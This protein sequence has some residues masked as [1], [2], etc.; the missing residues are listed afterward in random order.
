MAHDMTDI[1]DRRLLASRPSAADASAYACDE[2]LLDRLR[3][4]PIAARRA[5]P[6]KVATPVAAGVAAVAAGLLLLG[7]GPGSPDAA[8][9]VTQTLHWLTPSP[10]TI[11]H[12]RSVE[13]NRGDVTTRD[14]WQS[15]DDPS[16]LR[17]RIDGQRSFE[18]SGDEYYDPATN[19]IYA[20]GD[21]VNKAKLPGAIVPPAK[22]GSLPAGDPMVIK[23]RMLLAAGHMEVGDLDHHNG[24][25]AWPIS[26][27]PGLDRQPWTL[28]VSADDG[29]PLELHDGYQTIRWTAYDVTSGDGNAAV[30]SVRAAHPDAQVVTD[31][32]AVMQAEARLEGMKQEAT[33]EKR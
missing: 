22:D 28:W 7:G 11:L 5:V 6:V 21:G 1:L 20:P 16:K 33:G 3:E 4:Q 25:D 23:V 13:T 9:A 2:A 19:T 18:R 27:K 24:V 31:P 10:G 17:E 14:Y 8:A 29:K 15:G 30:L 32:E 12:A 26:L